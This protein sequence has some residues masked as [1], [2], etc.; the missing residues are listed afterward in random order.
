MITWLQNA[1]GKHHRI[2]F[3]FLLVIIVAS[4]VFYGFAGRGAL[5]GTGSYMYLGVD[6]NDPAVRQRHRDA[7]FF[8]S[9]TGQRMDNVSL[10]QRVAELSLANS[11]HIPEPSEAE[12]RKIAREATTPPDGKDAGDALAKFIDFASKQLVA[13]DLDT[14]VR[15]ERF[16][17]DTWRINKAMA[18]L[19]GPG[20]ATAGQVKRIVDRERTNWTVDAATAVFA[21]FKAVVADDEA[22]AKA[23]FETNKEAYRLPARIESTAVVIT[24]TVPDTAPVSDDEVISYGY[25]VAEKLKLDTGKI[26]EQALAR[27]AEIEKMIRTERAVTNLAGVISDELAEKFPMESTKADNKAFADWLKTR[28]AQLRPLPA[29]DAGNPPQVD[30]VPAEAL[31]VAGDLTDKE[32][33]TDVYRTEEGAVFIILGKRTESRLPEFSEVKAL[34]LSNWKASERARLFTDEVGRLNK[35][36]Q[37]DAA[38]GK[39]FAE[40]ARALG[41]VVSSPAAFTAFSV[42]ENLMGSTENTGQLI[43]VAGVGKITPPI[44][45]R[46]GDYVFIRPAK[47]ELGK[48]DSTAE[49]TKLFIQRIASRNAYFTSMGLIQDLT[50]APEPAGE[51]K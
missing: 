38:A 21:D 51:A 10:Q 31:R 17:K 45:T 35:A 5:H 32:W 13:S 2:I 33:H 8:A 41:L 46:N 7:Q 24:Q 27:R 16:I 44:R 25:N 23:A 36:L 1:T 39:S 9:M 22:K 14:R 11:L 3:G 26:K 49:E 29:F 40:S 30:K 20:H 4:F 6:L 47:S 50:A 15:F 42:P 48:N 18:I 12:I 43:E 28:G 34:A 37:A 19:S